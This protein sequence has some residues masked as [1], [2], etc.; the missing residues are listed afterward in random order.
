MQC[1]VSYE[2]TRFVLA[3]L[4]FKEAMYA[5]SQWHKQFVK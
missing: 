2:K 3:N 5:L 4:Y 1:K